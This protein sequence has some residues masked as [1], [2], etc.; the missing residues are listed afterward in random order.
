MCETFSCHWLYKAVNG[1]HGV[2]NYLELISLTV[3]T[4]VEVV[5]KGWFA[6]NY[7][8]TVYNIVPVSYTHLDVYKRQE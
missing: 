1:E 5:V 7:P 8:G 6:S 2:P 3:E 4:E